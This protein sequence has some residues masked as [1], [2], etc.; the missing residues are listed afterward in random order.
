[1]GDELRS[2]RLRTQP[3]VVGYALALALVWIL[4]LVWILG[5]VLGLIL[6]F[7]F[8]VNFGIR[9]GAEGCSAAGRATTF[10][11]IENS[12]LRFPD[13]GKGD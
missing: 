12:N 11:G 4:V 9:F 5:L 7:V 10:W 2:S 8:G 6:A 13:F 1:M 3:G